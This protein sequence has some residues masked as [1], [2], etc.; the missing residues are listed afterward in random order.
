[1][2]PRGDPAASSTRARRSRS[3]RR[4]TS[5]ARTKFE[6]LDY[7]TV[8]VL[9]SHWFTTVEFV[10]TSQDLRAGLF[11]AEELPRGMCRIPYEW[12]GDRELA[13]AIA[14]EGER[15][16]HVDHADRRPVPPAL[17]PVDQPVVV[18]RQG[19]RQAVDLDVAC[20]RPATPRTSC[21]SGAPS[22]QA[23]AE[24][25]PQGDHH[26]HGL[27]VAHVLQAARAARSTRRATRRTS[28]ARRRRDMDHER[29]AVVLRG[30]P[31][32]R[33]RDDA[34]FLTVRPEGKFAHYLMMAAALGEDDF[35][36]ARR[37]VRRLRELDRHQPGAR[38]VR[39]SRD[40]LDAQGSRWQ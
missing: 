1:M 19:P 5:C 18:P 3:S 7:D 4:C 40:R 26:R 13:E 2:L 33:A 14:A 32:P 22:A 34:E 36:G 24:G 6:T 17:L 37:A 27:A 29:L 9:D 21:A 35:C 20:A 12:R 39:P 16:R 10:V 25:R 28:S 15:E 23:I 8:I 38:L 30:P 11:T 31:R